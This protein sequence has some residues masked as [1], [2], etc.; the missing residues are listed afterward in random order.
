MDFIYRYLVSKETVVLRQWESEN[1]LL[2]VQLLAERLN[3][4]LT[5]RALALHQSERANA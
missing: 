5:F 4:G 1:K 2:K 3:R